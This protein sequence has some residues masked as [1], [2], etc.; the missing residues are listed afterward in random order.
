MKASVLVLLFALIVTSAYPQLKFNGLLRNDASI[1]K[2]TNAAPV[3]SDTL[4]TRL[5]LSEKAEQWRF[6]ADARV[7]L[8]SGAAAVLTG[9]QMKI[10]LLRAFIR[11]Y[12]PVGDFTVGK[13]YINFGAMG[14]FN[15]LE[16]AK[17]VTFSDLKYDREGLIALQYELPIGS[18]TKLMMYA[19]PSMNWTNCAGGMQFSTHIGTFDLGIAVNRKQVNRTVVGAYFKGDIEL[20]VTGGYAFHIDDYAKD[21]FSEA[22]LGLE[23]SFLD[24]KLVAN[25]I[26]YYDQRGAD[27]IS[28][29]NLFSTDD[30]YF[31][32]KWYLYGALS[33]AY[34]EFI[35][36]G[37]SAFVNLIDFSSV[38]LPSFSYTVS[39]GL[40]LQLIGG[41]L[42]GTGK[43]EFSRD[44]LGE[45]SCTARLETKL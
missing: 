4:E 29:Y 41:I 16:A 9:L 37:V 11:F 28:N 23:Y 8:Y 22:N 32:A 15:P 25:L 3:F 45:F 14:V 12:T 18:E 35:S 42:T 31:N 33:Y 43:S 38:I 5:I 20:A 39:D 27:T 26:G 36:F 2:Q 17:T 40:T 34:D 19:S 1:A 21:Y 30:K 13:T 7:Y 24:G 44:K 10:N 6:Y